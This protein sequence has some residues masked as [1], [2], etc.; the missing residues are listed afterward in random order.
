MRTPL[1]MRAMMKV[2]NQQQPEDRQE[3][4]RMRQSKCYDEEFEHASVNM[5]EAKD[6]L[7]MSN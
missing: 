7:P 1:M 5:D 6:V 4:N 3:T 2:R